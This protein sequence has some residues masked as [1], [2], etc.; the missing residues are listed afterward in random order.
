[1][2]FQVHWEASG[3]KPTTQIAYIWS[4]MSWSFFWV[5]RYEFGRK[6]IHLVGF[7]GFFYHSWSEM[8]K[9][10]RFSGDK[11]SKKCTYNIQFQNQNQ[12][13]QSI[14]IQYDTI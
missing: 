2:A 14:K 5:L 10:G 13:S 12:E 7:L 11:I 3:L 4:E 1:M 8:S 6:Y 9:F